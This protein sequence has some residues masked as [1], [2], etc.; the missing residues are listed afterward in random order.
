MDSGEN[1]FL[2]AAIERGLNIENYICYWTAAS[3]TARDRCN[4]KCA[5]IVTTILHLDEGARPAMQARQWLALD[6]FQVEHRRGKVEGLRNQVIFLRV[7]DNMQNIGKSG[8]FR[9]LESRPAAGGNDFPDA[10]PGDLAN[11]AARRRGR[12]V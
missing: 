2:C 6:R 4:A 10:E 12:I 8:S 11:L 7:G 9:R 1:D 3:L 5:V